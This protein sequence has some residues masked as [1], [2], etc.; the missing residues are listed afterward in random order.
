MLGGLADQVGR[1]IGKL[2]RRR[3]VR[4]TGGPVKVNIGAGIEV[5]PGWINVYG[6]IHALFAGAPTPVLRLLHR[7]S[8]VMRNGLPADEYVRRLSEHRFVHRELEDGLP[9][10]SG[11]VD[12]IFCSHVLEH[13]YKVHGEQLLQEMHRVLRPGGVVRI[14]VPDLG[15]AVSLYAQGMKRESLH[16]FF[17]DSPAGYY[18][19]HRYLYDYEL[20]EEAL[21][22]AGFSDIRRCEFQQGRVPDLQLLDNRP[23]ET[24]Y[25]EASR[26]A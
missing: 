7:S 23:E 5:A 22:A 13:F 3:R 10:E 19:Q 1:V 11:S 16:Y 8:N 6:G 17:V 9:F 4:L 14:C 26:T 18:R 21:A 20:L 12:Y 2:K 15:H 24:L 25:V